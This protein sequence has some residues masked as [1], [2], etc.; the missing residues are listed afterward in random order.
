MHC[1]AIL[2]LICAN[3]SIVQ[4]TCIFA[5]FTG[6]HSYSAFHLFDIMTEVIDSL[7]VVQRS[8]LPFYGPL[9]LFLKA[10]RVRH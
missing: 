8:L 3:Y 1:G 2:P 5:D 6:Y 7:D 10:R 4:I 9:L